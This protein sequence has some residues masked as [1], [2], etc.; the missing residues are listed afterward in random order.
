VSKE[1]YTNTL[2]QPFRL[3]PS[4]ELPNRILMAP[5]TRSMASDDLV[6]SSATADYYARRADAGLLI[7]EATI[8]TANGQG[9]PNTPG[10]FTD[11]QVAGWRRVTDKI[12]N[13][14]GRVFVQLWHVGRVSHPVFLNGAMPVAPSAV[15][16]EG[17]V[18][19]T[20]DLEYSTPRAL[21]PDEIL[22]LIE[23][24]GV[25]ATNALDAG[26]D[27]IELHGANGYLIDQFLHRH[28]NR[29]TDQWGGPPENMI[30]FALKVVDR[31]IDAAGPDRVAIRLSPGAYF[32]MDPD[33]DDGEV[34][35][36][37]LK[38]L[39]E[40]GLAY[41]HEGIFDDS[42]E[43]DYLNGRVSQFLRNHYSGVL[44]GNG[45]YTPK[46][47]ADAIQ[48]GRFDLVSIGQL[49]IANPDLIQKLSAGIELDAYDAAML[50]TLT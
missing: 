5:M 29:R 3:T 24:W 4:L 6:P 2:L 7:T 39:D 36:L 25:A 13:A 19:R 44:V 15:R 41:V 45:S 47:G 43:F 40:R 16:L 35:T 42:M 30:Q 9:Y 17:R 20:N 14:G 8:I 1:S 28:T 23:Q 26:F 32:N 11:L 27:G 49:F 46:T 10:M 50:A 48:A 22:E 18:H 12:H 33:P 38:A 34:F 31:V 21:E 37:L